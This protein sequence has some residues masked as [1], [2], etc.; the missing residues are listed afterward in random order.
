MDVPIWLILSQYG[1]I[2]MIQ[3]RGLW[4]G[5]VNGCVY[6]SSGDM[7]KRQDGVKS[8]L[9]SEMHPCTRLYVC[10]MNRRTAGALQF[11]FSRRTL[12]LKEITSLIYTRREV[13]F[14]IQDNR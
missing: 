3:Y 7:T 2:A 8:Q 13:L 11:T 4:A 12:V 14:L 1:P 6:V 9:S 10:R 5:P